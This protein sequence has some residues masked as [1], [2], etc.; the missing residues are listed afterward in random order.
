[1]SGD[2]ARA[3]SALLLAGGAVLGLLGSVVGL[4]V[5]GGAVERREDSAPVGFATALDAGRVPDEFVP[6]IERAGRQCAEVS[7]PLLAAQIQ[8]ESG[9]NPDAVSPASAQGLSQFIPGTWETWGVDAAGK[10]GSPRPDGVADPFTPGD[11]IMTQARYDCWLAGK[12]EDLG[13]GGD[14]TRLLLAAYNAGPGA[15]EEYGGVPPYPETQAYVATIIESMADFTGGA[16]AEEDGGAFGDRVVAH[17]KEWLGTPYSWGGGGPEGPSRGF[18][19]GADTVGFDCS[20]F[21]QYAVYHASGGRVLLPRVSQLQVTEGVP[22]PREDM[23]P[24]D[25]IGF[26]QH[27]SYDHIGIYL[28]G[29]QLIHAPKTGDVVKISDLDEPYYDGMPQIVRRFG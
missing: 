10:D 17:A 1:M 25:V 27:G 19:Q 8:A 21:V 20:S 23:R 11:A 24:G 4:S 14:T 3:R 26:N 12:V 18:A 9:W 13:L 28:G 2:T 16:P 29:G 7:A 6:W 5:V 22:V 15:V